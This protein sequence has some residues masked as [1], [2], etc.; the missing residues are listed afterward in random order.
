[1]SGA[2]SFR[3]NAGGTGEACDSVPLLHRLGFRPRAARA[4][5]RPQAARR[6]PVRLLRAGRLPSFRA[7]APLALSSPVTQLSKGSSIRLWVIFTVGCRWCI[8]RN[9]PQPG[10]PRANR[11]AQLA[12]SAEHRDHPRRCGPILSVRHRPPLDRARE[13]RAVT[14]NSGAG[15]VQARSDCSEDMAPPAAHR[16]I[17]NGHRGSHIH[18]RCHRNDAANRATRS[19]VVTENRP[20]ARPDHCAPVSRLVDLPET[21]WPASPFFHRQMS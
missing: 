10:C 8:M 21:A 4:A 3:G 13:G 15:A 14:G 1:M 17:V 2:F 11:D 6:D 5:N 7:L 12:F 9:T 19:G 20:L 16:P 18:G